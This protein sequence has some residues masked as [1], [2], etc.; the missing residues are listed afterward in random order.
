M[1]ITRNTIIKAIVD[2]SGAY[3]NCTLKGIGTEL[4]INLFNSLGELAYTF[5][6]VI[7]RLKAKLTYF[8]IA[9]YLENHPEIKLISEAKTGQFSKRIEL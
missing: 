8:E 5:K 3:P 6:T 1:N 7:P 4:S 2:R 9:E